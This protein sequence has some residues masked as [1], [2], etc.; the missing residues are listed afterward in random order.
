MSTKRATKEQTKPK[1]YVKP[2]L[3][4]G[5]TLSNVSAE[6]VSGGGKGCWIAR[7]AFGED[8]FRWMIFRAW[9][10]EDAPDWFRGLY[11]RF[12]EGLGAWIKG[13]E[14][15]RRLVRGAMLPAIRRKLV[16]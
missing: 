9:L 10:L 14:A 7:A 4:K 3:R 15:A 2:V 8:D 12:G 11:F 13:R 16:T 6:Q 5:P 1:I